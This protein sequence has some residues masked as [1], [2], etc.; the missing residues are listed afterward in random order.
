MTRRFLL[1]DDAALSLFDGMTLRLPL[2][3]VSVSPG[4]RHDAPS[5]SARAV[6]PRARRELALPARARERGPPPRARAG[7]RPVRR[8]RDAG[9]CDAGGG[10]RDRWFGR[11]R[12]GAREARGGRRS[13]IHGWREWRAVGPREGGAGVGR[14]FFTHDTSGAWDGW[15]SVR[16][17]SGGAG[18]GKVRAWCSRSY[19]AYSAG[20]V[21]HLIALVC[22]RVRLFALRSP[23][24]VAVGSTLSLRH[25]TSSGGRAAGTRAGTARGAT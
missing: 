25:A 3:D 2:D 12:R 14:S 11:A 10:R 21:H 7:A 23:L 5:R 16:D 1:V 9:A 6:R 13:L 20:W 8:P 4:R 15:G 24:N 17:T 22:R 19:S 18:R